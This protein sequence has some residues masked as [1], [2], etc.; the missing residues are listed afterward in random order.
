MTDKPD[1]CAALRKWSDRLRD[2]NSSLAESLAG[3]ADAWEA[4]RAGDTAMPVRG[5]QTGEYDVYE[6]DVDLAALEEQSGYAP[7]ALVR[8]SDAKAAIKAAWDAN[9][10]ATT[11][12]HNST[13]AK[14]ARI[15][16]LEQALQQSI[17]SNVDKIIAMTDDQVSALTRLDG[18]NPEDS[19]RLGKQACELAIA[20]VRIAEQDEEIARLRAANADAMHQAAKTLE[21]LAL[22][23][24]AE[25]AYEALMWAAGVIE[26]K[27]E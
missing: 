12:L 1:M 14:D 2:E 23:S 7:Q 25:G 5:Y 27:P 8:Q 11:E 9:Y 6:H 17:E 22:A 16:E 4:E 26:E 13:A 3:Y 20:A 19:A 21:R 15:A 18:S 24:S 10:R